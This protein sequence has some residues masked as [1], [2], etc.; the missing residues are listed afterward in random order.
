[1]PLQAFKTDPTERL[2]ISS[3]MPLLGALAHD[4]V[5]QPSG[6]GQVRTDLAELIPCLGQIFFE[7]LTMP[8][9]IE[10][11]PAGLTRF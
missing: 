6:L 7:L 9:I 1:M 4:E 3:T 8:F 11:L 5:A 10:H 2:A